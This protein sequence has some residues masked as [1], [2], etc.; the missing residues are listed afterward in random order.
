MY[1]EKS[2]IPESA[3]IA[4]SST[5]IKFQHHQPKLKAVPGYGEPADYNGSWT[6]GNVDDGGAINTPETRGSIPATPQ[7]LILL[8]MAKNE[9]A[10]KSANAAIDSSITDGMDYVDR[11]CARSFSQSHDHGFGGDGLRVYLP[12]QRLCKSANRAK[13]G[14]EDIGD[15]GGEWIMSRSKFEQTN[16]PPLP[17]QIADYLQFLANL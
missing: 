17:T 3:W 8:T 9:I 10:S 13:F 11:A 12:L 15:F 5:L 7:A 14:N 6:G 1:E 2:K 4:F 16:G